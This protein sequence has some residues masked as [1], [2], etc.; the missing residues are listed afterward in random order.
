MSSADRS[1]V[2]QPETGK[3]AA[4]IFPVAAG[5]NSRTLD[6]ATAN[7]RAAEA[8]RAELIAALPFSKVI[9]ERKS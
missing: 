1:L 4:S 6:D 7:M 3:S 9:E 8:R 5:S 2:S